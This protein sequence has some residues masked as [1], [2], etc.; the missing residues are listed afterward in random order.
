[1]SLY[2]QLS[3]QFPNLEFQADFSLKEKTY[4]KIGGSA[5]I[6][7]ETHTQ[8]GFVSL[9]RYCQ[10]EK[11]HFTL[12]GG[13][14]NIIVADK[15]I[16]G[17]VIHPKQK[18]IRLLDEN[19]LYAETGAKTSLVVSQSVKYGLT[20]LEFFLGVP[21]SI[22]GAIYNNAHYLE[23]LMSDHIYQVKILSQEGEVQLLEN[24]ACDFGYDSSRFQTSGEVILGVTFSLTKGEEEKS[25]ELIKKA[26]LYRAKTQPLGKPSSGCIFQ[27]PPNTT[28]LRKQFPQFK[29]RK[30][31]PAGFLIDQAGLK[32]TRVGGVEVS[33]KHASF[34]INNGEGTA[35]DLK[36]LISLVKKR[37]AEKFGVKLQEEVFYLE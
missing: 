33:S 29:D 23:D 9:L 10:Q 25:R 19:L 34:F 32:K 24:K 17:L 12:L 2:T 7:V 1:M 21:G 8:E 18:E 15:G 35:A 22:G 31:I 30:F 6:Y 16:E 13:G 37:V 11:I 3:K 36:K 14:S 26:T 27:N 4:F 20:G 5:E 28:A